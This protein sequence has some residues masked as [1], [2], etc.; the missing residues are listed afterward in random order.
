MREKRDEILERRRRYISRKGGEK[1]WIKERRRREQ[2]RRF[3]E[4]CKEIMK[5]KTRGRGRNEKR[6]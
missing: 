3:K 2:I 6:I 1:G 5:E 4:R